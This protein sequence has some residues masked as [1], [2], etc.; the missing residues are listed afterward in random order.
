MT[1]ILLDTIFMTALS[2]VFSV[3]VHK[4]ISSAKLEGGSESIMAPSLETNAMDDEEVTVLLSNGPVPLTDKAVS[5]IAPSQLEV[6]TIV[7]GFASTY[8]A[9]YRSACA[10]WC[11]AQS[12]C[13][14]S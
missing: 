9:A 4:L 13:L 5:S 11:L 3:S 10:V 2:R 14:S 7:D 12:I 8:N 6:A 1:A